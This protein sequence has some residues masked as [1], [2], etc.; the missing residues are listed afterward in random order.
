MA[1]EEKRPSAGSQL[2]G[3]TTEIID[4]SQ[5]EDETS[6]ESQLIV[7]SESFVKEQ[8]KNHDPS[9]DWQHVHRVRLMALTIS[10]CPSLPAKPDP[11]V[12][13]LAA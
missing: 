5:E 12:L 8:F 2:A 6:I 9:H 1:E 4:L 3:A 7:A 11:V 13:E 10:R